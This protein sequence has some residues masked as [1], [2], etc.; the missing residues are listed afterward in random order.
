MKS[1]FKFTL[2]TLNEVLSKATEAA[3]AAGDEWMKNAA[4]KY[5]VT[6]GSS[7]SG[8]ML[9]VCGNAHVRFYDKRKK[10]FREFDK[11]GFVS[12]V[13]VLSIPHKFRYRQEYGLQ[14]ACAEA[15]ANSLRDQGVDG[16]RI[17]SYVD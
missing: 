15:A 1:E 14:M 3:N 5:V 6:D 2:Q 13:D 10:W 9:D 16:I 11:A 8:I 17:W 7:I 4:P 12:T